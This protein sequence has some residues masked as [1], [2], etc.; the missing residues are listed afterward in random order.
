MTNVAQEKTFEDRTRK[1][2]MEFL[3]NVL[4]VDDLIGEAPSPHAKESQ[5]P[6]V[7]PSPGDAEVDVSVDENRS[8]GEARNL[9]SGTLVR[10][11]AKLG[12][13]CAPLVPDIDEAEG[14]SAFVEGI[15]QAAER[16][17]I[18]VLDWWMR[19][20]QDWEETQLSE[21][22]L[23]RVLKGDED[24]GG[25]LR[26][27]TIYTAEPRI[28]CI[29]GKVRAVLEGFYQD[30]ATSEG[31]TASRPG[32]QWISRG[33]IRVVVVN[34]GNSSNSSES[35]T[36]A[37]LANFSVDEYASITRGLLRH[38]A[39]QGLTVLR[40][41]AHQVLATFDPVM[42]PAYLC[43][44]ALVTSDTWD[45]GSV[46]ETLGAELQSI[47][48]ERFEGAEVP[49]ELVD[50]WLTDIA[51]GSLQKVP[52]LDKWKSSNLEAWQVLLEKGASHSRQ[53]SS[54]NL[55][56][57]IK[58]LRSDATKAL[59][60]DKDDVCDKELTRMARTAN[61]RFA[62]LM[63][64]K[65]VYRKNPPIL[66]LGTVLHSS[67]G[68]K[69]LLCLQPKCDSVRLESET[70]FPL[71]DLALREESEQY[72]LVIR[73]GKD[74][75]G[76]DKWVCLAVQPRTRNL[77][78]PAFQPDPGRRVVSAAATAQE[79]KYLFW[80]TKCIPYRWVGMIKD[81]HAL[82][83]A[84]RFASNIARPGPNDSEWLRLKAPKS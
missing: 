41:R 57:F 61:F 14:D 79:G 39:L 52:G 55:Q 77:V 9:D 19:T 70:P 12:I 80:D 53:D 5:E 84:G 51:G 75:D 60:P 43:H 23:G 11:F 38:V 27:V 13:L 33:P 6:V 29:L 65:N 10:S 59:I 68:E 42:D 28:D 47:L 26:L 18:L 64:N 22:V 69:Y 63:Q 8:A 16:A 20:Q 72:D 4:L 34:K 24:A 3:R 2:A 67:S 30:H 1:A 56:N 71:L 82:K 54:K 15:A 83:V 81:E 40:E 48:E 17:D 74:D 62:S 49:W 73:D 44:R 45:E 35:V 46:V 31:S 25:K 32:A 7:S 78:L 37:E 36:E 58:G 76:N 21:K 66:T 50:G